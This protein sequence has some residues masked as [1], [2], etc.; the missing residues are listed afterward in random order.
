MTDWKQTDSIFLSRASMK[1]TTA[2]LFA[3]H[4]AGTHVAYG[5]SAP[6]HLSGTERLAGI[7][8]VASP[9]KAA[10]VTRW[11]DDPAS[12]T[13]RY[14]NHRAGSIPVHPSNH[15]ALR[16]NPPAAARALSGTGVADSEIL[17]AARVHK[18]QD[19]LHNVSPVDGWSPTPARKREARTLLKQLKTTVPDN[20]KWPEWEPER[21]ISVETARR[22]FEEYCRIIVRKYGR[23]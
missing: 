23:R 1:L 19:I 8:D 22:D 21:D 13:G 18:L 11:M 9:D 15:G 4:V 16:H 14:L 17:N 5:M 7:R 20:V 10:A 6:Q 2:L 12:K 3:V